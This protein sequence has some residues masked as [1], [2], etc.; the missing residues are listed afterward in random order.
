VPLGIL[1]RAV[2]CSNVPD[3]FALGPTS[4]TMPRPRRSPGRALEQLTATLERVLGT[5]TSAH[6]ESPA[7]LTDR[8]TGERREHDVLLR[9]KT[10]HHET[11]IAI[12]C[13]DRSRKITVNDVEGFYMKCRDTG[14]D[15]GVVVSS[16][17]FSRTALFKAK[18]RNIRTLLL[19]DAR[20]FPWLGTAGITGL[21]RRIN[22]ISC[23]F[24]PEQ[25]LDPLPQTYSVLMPDGSPIHPEQVKASAR[26]EFA[27]IPHDQTAQSPGKKTIIFSTPGMTLYDEA[28]KASYPLK[29]AVVEVHYDLIEEFIPFRLVSYKDSASGQTITDAAMAELKFGDVSGQVMVVYKE[30]EGG[31][32]VFV[33]DGPGGA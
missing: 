21:T 32:V 22:H 24:E 16:K 3:T 26:A 17:G 2:P 23:M 28:A 19:N 1:R 25:Q 18:V 8:V 31:R 20:S 6:I 33:P 27:K 10:S 12:E 7:H 9:I 11:L 4:A 13:R 5:G 29:R 15:Q 14:V 30:A